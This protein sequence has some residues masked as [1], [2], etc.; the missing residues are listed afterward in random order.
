MRFGMKTVGI[1]GL[2]MSLAGI[3]ACK[4]SGQSGGEG[5]SLEGA[6]TRASELD[7]EMSTALKEFRDQLIGSDKFPGVKNQTDLAK[8]IDTALEKLE[9]NEYKDDDIRFV[10]SQLIPIKVLHGIIW[11]MTP[12]VENKSDTLHTAVVSSMMAIASGTR[13]FTPQNSNDT[14]GV[15][16]VKAVN[17]YL[18]WPYQGLTTN[19]QFKSVREL[20]DF[21]GKE[22]IPAIGRT[23]TIIEGI[24]IP[25][26]KPL[27]WDN[28]MVFGK[29]AFANDTDSKDR[30]ATIY[31]GEKYLALSGLFA[32]RHNILF[33][34]QYNFDDFPDYFKAAA[35]KI[36]FEGVGQ[37]GVNGIS[38][39]DR[40]EV[41]CGRDTVRCSTYPDLFKKFN[42]FNVMPEAYSNLEKSTEYLEK[43]WADVKSRG[44]QAP[45]LAGYQLLDPAKILPWTR[46]NDSTVNNIRAMVKGQPVRSAISGKMITVNV[47]KF[48][49]NPPV[50]LK[51]FLPITFD[52]APRRITVDGVDKVRNY[53]YGRA[54]Q[55]NPAAYT[56]YFPDI[57]NG[58][59]VPTVMRDLSQVWGG[60]FA[61]VGLA[62]VSMVF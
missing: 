57:Q 20:Q 4:K 43:A 22:L 60:W 41:L 51:S 53:E 42:D 54:D 38:A 27:V 52:Q 44:A 26:S 10:V 18:A 37:A 55:W 56:M 48:Y 19:H 29:G 32:I 16:V 39:R 31:E 33:F 7:G 61:N 59:Q 25:S 24:K 13:I 12:L 35:R 30:Y 23:T 34:R 14:D 11:R 28:L 8:L 47:P 62:T 3:T 9:K 58:Y 6:G 15:H 5:A 1:L 46:L 40:A 36:G 50:D 21:L 49:S 2:V 45:S 17:R